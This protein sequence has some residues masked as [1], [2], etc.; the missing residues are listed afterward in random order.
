MQ[1][2]KE[3]KIQPSSEYKHLVAS[4]TEGEGLTMIFHNKPLEAPPFDAVLER[5]VEVL[6]LPP[7]MHLQT[8]TTDELV[9]PPAI[10]GRQ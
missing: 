8:G 4:S 1:P 2:P 7:T 10:P 3:S 6:C 9:L 5:D